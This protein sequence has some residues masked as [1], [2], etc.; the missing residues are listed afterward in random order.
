MRLGRY[1]QTDVEWLVMNVEDVI[2]SNVLW[3][4]DRPDKHMALVTAVSPFRY[5][6]EKELIREV[7]SEM[8]AFAVSGGGSKLN[9]DM[10][11]KDYEDL[12]RIALSIIK[13][14]QETA[15]APTTETQ[16]GTGTTAGQ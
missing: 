4:S 3:M 14:S 15:N 2:K 16:E 13:K 8:Q 6:P 10:W 1:T 11:G 9:A 5:I 12:A 7:A